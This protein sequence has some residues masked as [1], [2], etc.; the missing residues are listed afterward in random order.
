M[1]PAVRKLCRNAFIHRE[2]KFN[3][4]LA[5]SLNYTC[6]SAVKYCYKKLVYALS[7]P[8]LPPSSK[9]TTVLAHSNYGGHVNMNIRFV[10]LPLC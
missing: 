8:P 7:P 1:V 4:N 10:I 9:H 5:S 3:E 6:S 2:K